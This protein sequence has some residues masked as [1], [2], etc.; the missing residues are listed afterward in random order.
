MF[1]VQVNVSLQIGRAITLAVCGLS[2]RRP[3]FH[4]RSV[5]MKF[6]LDKVGPGQV[7]FLILRLP[8]VNT[9]LF[10][11]HFHLQGQTGAD[12]EPYK[13]RC[14]FGNRSAFKVLN[15]PGAS[16]GIKY[17]LIS[18]FSFFQGIERHRHINFRIPCA[19]GIRNYDPHC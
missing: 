19:S 2:P 17:C 16:L 3:D 9:P 6:V 18:T 10:P 4:S 8:P 15:V 12:C 1:A 5:Y 13:K 7:C 14:S 11:A